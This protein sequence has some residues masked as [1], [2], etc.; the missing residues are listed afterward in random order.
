MKYK[1]LFLIVLCLLLL[2]ACKNETNNGADKAN[3]SELSRAAEVTLTDVQESKIKE[4]I[5]YL[6]D[7]E[8][9][10][11]ERLAIKDLNNQEKLLLMMDNEWKV[12]YNSKTINEWL[13]TYFGPN[14]NAQM[15]NVICPYDN[16]ILYAYNSATDSF[17]S[18]HLGH[19]Y[20]TVMV[21]YKILSAKKFE[22]KYFVE[23]VKAFSEGFDISMGDF[24]TL[25]KSSEDGWDMKNPILE[26]LQDTDYCSLDEY[27]DPSCDYDKI[28]EDNKDKFNTYIYTF[29]DQDSNLYFDNYEIKAS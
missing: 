12:E 15:E 10:K 26:N 29:I 13:H 2:S 19:G 14:I 7:D 16:G 17:E 21:Y 23:V 5:H 18:N 4:I 22:N 28:L 25:Y 6:P 27:G 11:D 1:N 24:T 3:E 20:S 8:P 9:S